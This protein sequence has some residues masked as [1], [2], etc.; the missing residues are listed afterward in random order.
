LN[1]SPQNN[2]SQEIDL[3]QISRKIGSFFDGIIFN[4]FRLIFLLKRKLLFWLDIIIIGAGLGYFLDKNFKKTMK[5][6]LWLCQILN[7]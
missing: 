4:I 1:N 6:K 5:I 7:Q 2:D 3:S